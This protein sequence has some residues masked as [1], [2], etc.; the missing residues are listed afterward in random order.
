M[1]RALVGM[2]L[3]HDQPGWQSTV[4]RLLD[5]FVDGLRMRHTQRPAARSRVA[6]ART[7]AARKKK[8]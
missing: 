8:R 5:V 3:M 1:I 2:S 7:S 6:A 4:S